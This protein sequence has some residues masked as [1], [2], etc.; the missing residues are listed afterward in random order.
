M[1]V[2]RFSLALHESA[3]ICDIAQLSIF[4]RGIDNFNDDNFKLMIILTL[5]SLCLSHSMEKQEDQTYLRK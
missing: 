2:L 3:G 5:K 1:H 4:V